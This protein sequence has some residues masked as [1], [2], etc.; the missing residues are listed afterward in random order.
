MKKAMLVPPSLNKTR[1]PIKRLAMQY[2]KNYDLFLLFLPVIVY[3][4]VFAYIPMYGVVLA[5]KKFQL[6]GGITGSPW[7]GFDNFK[8]IF[9]TGSFYEVLRNT[10]NISLLRLIFGFP[11]PI[12]LALLLNEITNKWF[13]KIIQTISYLPH[14]LSW[15]VLT[16]I[17]V[18]FLSPTSGPINFLITTIGFKSIYFLGQPNW[19]IFTLISTGIWQGI[20]W[21]SIIYLAAI[22]NIDQEMYESAELEGVSRFQRIIY[23]TLP[24]I[25]PT[26][27][28]LLILNVGGILNAG[29]DQIFNL[30]NDA[31]LNVADIIDTYVYR[32]G[33]NG[34]QYSYATAVGLFKNV[35]GF[36]LVLGTNA[37]TKRMSEYALW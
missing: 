13:K 26:V 31:V 22:S 21:G 7:V 3:Y 17:F 9:S 32:R 19:F 10:I 16:G 12:I 33:L 4:V 35:I 2:I 5:F 27:T 8:E 28:I 37:I 24:S 23:I 25:M 36:V 18:Q 6:L 20:G 29:F 15:I 30:Y 14:F 34:M 1:S 11:A